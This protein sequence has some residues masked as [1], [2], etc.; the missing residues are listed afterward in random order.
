MY[1]IFS[2]HEHKTFS[3]YQLVWEIMMHWKVFIPCWSFGFKIICL[4]FAKAFKSF[5]K[6]LQK[7]GMHL[8]FITILHDLSYSIQVFLVI[9]CFKFFPY[10]VRKPVFWTAFQIYSFLMQ[11]FSSF[12]SLLFV[13]FAWKH[14]LSRFCWMNPDMSV[15]VNFSFHELNVSSIKPVPERKPTITG[16]KSVRGM[17]LKLVQMFLYRQF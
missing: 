9:S 5:D 12:H 6:L 13:L 17:V 7:L 14:F 8:P 16:V 4:D 11:Y 10:A 3:H 1:D 15:L 2:M